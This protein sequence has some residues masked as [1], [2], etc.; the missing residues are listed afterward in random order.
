M[1]YSL[2]RL[3]LLLFWLS[4]TLAYAQGEGDYWYLA[5]TA[6]HFT[7]TG[8]AGIAGTQLDSEEGSATVSGA[9]GNLLFYTDG[10]TIKCGFES[11]LFNGNIAGQ[12]WR[13]RRDTVERAYGYRYDA[14]NRLLQGDFVA[15][16]GPSQAWQGERSNHRMWGLGYD[17]NG[18][19]MQLRRRGLVQTPTRLAPALF[20]ETDNLHY[21][22]DPATQGNRLKAV[23]DL[24]PEPSLFVASR[25]PE[26]PDFSDVSGSQDYAY[27]ANGSLL[28]D[29]NKRLSSIRYN[30]MHLPDKLVFGPANSEAQDSIRFVYSA[31]GQKVA[32]WVYARAKAPVRTDYL[33]AWQYE[34]DTLRWLSNAAGRA[35]RQ[36]DRTSG[37]ITYNYEYSLKD[38]LGNLRVAFRRGQRQQWLASLEPG[39]ASVETKQF[40]AA[41]VSAPIASNQRAASGSYS[42]MVYA[43]GT[44]PQPIGPMKLWAVQ[45]GDTLRVEALANYTAPA[46]SNFWHFALPTFVAGWLSQPAPAAN[47]DGS[48]TTSSFNWL[49]VGLAAGLSQLPNFGSGVP[50]AYLR[51][52]VYKA[53]STVLADRIVPITATARTSWEP[54]VLPQLVLPTGAAYAQVYVGNESNVSVWFDDVKIEHWQG[55]QVQENHY[56]PFGLDLAGLSRSTPGLRTLNQYQW[57]GKEKQSDFGLG[58]TNLDWRFFDPQTGRFHT[59]DPLSDLGQEMW[60][61]YQFGFDNAVRY[62][63]PNGKKPDCCGELGM[64]SLNS[65]MQAIDQK[66]RS[67]GSTVV[68]GVENMLNTVAE[69]VTELQAASERLV[70]EYRGTGGTQEH[71]LV[72]DSDKSNGVSPGGNTAKK[73]TVGDGKHVQTLLDAAGS[74]L[75]RKANTYKGAVT[76]NKGRSVSDVTGATSEAVD[77]RRQ[78]KQKQDSV[79]ASKGTLISSDTTGEGSTTSGEDGVEYRVIYNTYQ[80][81]KQ[82]TNERVLLPAGKSH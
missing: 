38:H 50:H 43:N 46:N 80:K 3:L 35:L 37:A 4:S 6:V 55:L 61:T 69:S 44:D 71:G 63:D 41:S 82:T 73:V 19:L 66:V 77:A 17:A 18:N 57:N 5:Y 70:A 45:G 53:D 14:A 79:A 16:S 52:L 15:R 62:N 7:P 48:S 1:R 23:D 24:A 31:T 36:Q 78:A 64:E 58:W 2:Q 47:P 56:D 21:R 29:Q 76:S 9:A 54:V 74:V 49:Q 68:N 32:K 39:A 33:G 28:S 27:D 59:V 10:S 22:Y 72:L 20:A 26:R 30:H 67:A 42:A 34:A 51:L 60:S 12:R 40:D 13:S 65:A 8:A 81:G 11:R 75:N 25:R